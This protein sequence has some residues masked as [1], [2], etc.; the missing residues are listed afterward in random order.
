MVVGR[1]FT[2]GLV[3][4][5]THNAIMIGGDWAGLHYVASSF[6]SFA[7]VVAL[8]Y[9]LHSAWTFPGAQRSRM[10]F[11]RYAVTMALNLPLSIAGMFVFVD[12]AG[13][14]VAISAPL[15]TVLLAA[16]NFIGGR[17]ALRVQSRRQT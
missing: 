11:A 16:F 3:C 15:V 7:V 9:W 5:L 14:S 12:L 6:V 8:G 1:F 17:W 13:L 10:S 2:V 4:A